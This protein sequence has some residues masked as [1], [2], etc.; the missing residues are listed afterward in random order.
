ME[1][2]ITIH[3]EVKLVVHY[4][5]EDLRVIAQD[6]GLADHHE[7]PDCIILDAAY[8]DSFDTIVMASLRGGVCKMGD[9]PITYEEIEVF[10]LE[11]SEEE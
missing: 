3:R 11:E 8:E 6:A 4:T 2:T 1:A 5:D 7:L 10:G 9:C